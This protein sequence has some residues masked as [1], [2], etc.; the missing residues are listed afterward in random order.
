MKVQVVAI[1]LLFFSI[2][3]FSDKQVSDEEIKQKVDE[4]MVQVKKQQRQQ[5]KNRGSQL[6]PKD[7][8]N[9]VDLINNLFNK[10]S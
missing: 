6:S 5:E 8:G 2:D 3:C 9:L 4:A 10:G 1:L 7:V